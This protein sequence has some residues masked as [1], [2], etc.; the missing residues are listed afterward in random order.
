MALGCSGKTGMYG[1]PKC[2]YLWPSDSTGGTRNPNIWSQDFRTNVWLLD[3]CKNIGGTLNTKSIN[4]NLTIWRGW[5]QV[6]QIYYIIHLEKERPI[7][8]LRFPAP[9]KFQLPWEWCLRL[10]DSQKLE[11]SWNHLGQCA[12]IYF[13]FHFSSWNIISNELVL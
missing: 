13:I 2:D 12:S 11:S 7:N 9:W 6:P 8:F 3:G 10:K 4:W 1:H 5:A